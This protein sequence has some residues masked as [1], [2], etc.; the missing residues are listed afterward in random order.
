MKYIRYIYTQ[1]SKRGLQGYSKLVIHQFKS[2]EKLYIFTP[3]YSAKKIKTLALRK[4]G[5]IRKIL[6]MDRRRVQCPTPFQKSNFSNTY[7]ILCKSR[8]QNVWC[9]LFLLDFV[10]LFKIFY[11]FFQISRLIFHHYH[12]SQ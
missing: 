6:K 10:N 5:N 12:F 11:L 3:C 8:Y 1:I 7:K 9:C 2:D 4:L